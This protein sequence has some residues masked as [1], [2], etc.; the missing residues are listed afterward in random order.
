MSDDTFD[1]TPRATS[2]DDL[3]AVGA[4]V[5]GVATAE[6]RAHAE[7]SPELAALAETWRLQQG[8]VADRTSIAAPAGAGD[9][10]LA[11]AMAVYDELHATPVAASADEGAAHTGSSLVS[12]ERRQRRYRLVMGAAAAVAVLF[13]GAVVVGNGLGGSSDDSSAGVSDPAASKMAPTAEAF[14]A[15]DQLATAT[16]DAATATAAGSVGDAG[17]GTD[18]AVAAESTEGPLQQAGTDTRAAGASEAVEA[19]EAPPSSGSVDQ[20][21]GPAEVVVSLATP[22]QL[23]GFARSRTAQLPL[24][25]FE[26]TCVPAGIEAL[27][28]AEYQGLQVVVTRD[29]ATGEVAAVEL[30]S[31]DPVASITP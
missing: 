6:E 30:I 9:A 24:P 25:G 20:I 29:P 10:A 1:H 13:V 19:T 28:L 27:G 8:R 14:T 21:A 17:E 18:G 12:F 26:F 23:L 7:A 3:L 2:D 5:D 22:E 4:L 16:D 31:C 11:A 15:D